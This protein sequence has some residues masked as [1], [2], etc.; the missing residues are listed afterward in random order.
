[1]DLSEY[2]L[3]LVY[4][5]ISIF[6]IVNPLQAALVFVSLTSGM[7]RIVR[8]KISL[9]ATTIALA[10]ALVFALAG[11]LILNF[12][13]I[14]IDSLRIAGGILLFLVSLDMVRGGREHKKVTEDEMRDANMR[15][16]ISV[17][18][19]AMLLL[20]GPGAMTTVVVQ[21]GAASGLVEKALVVLA[22]ILT[23]AIAYLALRF[24]D[25]LD[26]ALGVT[27]I[28]VLTR[29]Q[30]LILGAIAVKF[31]TTGLANTFRTLFPI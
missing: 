17:F 30:G 15:E 20:T 29:I 28:M 14:T 2:S 4:V 7:K 22:I 18:P 16:D 27:G 19:L 10:I 9:R 25:Q 26:K 23:F 8:E 1:M 11:D 6:V 21:M 31:I 12:F 3:Y 24:S 5:F 13:G